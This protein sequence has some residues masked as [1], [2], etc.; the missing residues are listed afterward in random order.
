VTGMSDTDTR[1]DATA[2]KPRRRAEAD[3][4]AELRLR[5][6]PP[7]VMRLSRKAIGMLATVGGLGLGAI[8]IVA[9]QNRAA[10]DGGPELFSTER[11]QQAEGLT[12]LP[13]DYGDVPQLGPPLPGE[14]GR[15]V[16]SAQRRGEPVPPVTTPAAPAVDPAEQLRLQEEEAAPPATGPLS[17]TSSDLTGLFPAAAAGTTPPDAVD[18][19]EDFLSREVDRRATAADRLQPPASP[20]VLQAGS[21]IEAALITGLRSDLPGQISAQV[22]ANVY[23]SPSGRFLLIPQGARL[24][25]EYDSRVALGQRRLLLAWTRLILPDGRSIVLERQ[26][27]TDE[28][29]YAGLEDRVD[30]HWGRLFLAAGLATI[31]NIGAELGRDNDND[32]ARAIRDGT[33]DTVGRAGEEIVRRQLQIAPTLT[34]RPGFPVRVMVTRDLILEPYGE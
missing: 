3:I 1:P 26:P 33:Q 2:E 15:P 11:V 12:Q 27:G 23:D 18:R 25:G 28:G 6:D 32:I 7:R 10:N 29:G 34:I 20:Y 30:N 31:L 4:A 22:T 9:L 17:A 16:L 8:L 24:L 14:L 19:R 5:P 21:V 13:R